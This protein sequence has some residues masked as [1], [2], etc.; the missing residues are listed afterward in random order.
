M[1]ILIFGTSGFIGAHLAR[2]A[3]SQGHGDG[4]VYGRIRKWA[5]PLPVIPLPD[6]GYGTAEL[7]GQRWRSIQLCMI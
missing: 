2:Y 3:A 1:R 6:G 5:R 4:G 7:G